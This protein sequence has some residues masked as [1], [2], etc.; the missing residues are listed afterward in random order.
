MLASSK[1]PWAIKRGRPVLQR[2]YNFASSQYAAAFEGVR[3]AVDVAKLRTD[4]VSYIEAFDPS[5]WHTQPV[6]TL[7]R[8]EALS[9]S[10][11]GGGTEGAEPAFV[12]TL[13]AFNRVNGKQV[14]ASPLVL[15][16]VIEHCRD[17]TNKAAADAEG[18]TANPQQQQQQR[19]ALKLAI[20]EVE[21]RMLSA[22]APALIGNQA[23]DFAKQ[24]GVTE[25][26]ESLEA[27]PVEQR[28]NDD[29]LRDEAK[30]MLTVCRVPALVGAVSNFSNFL[31]LCRKTLRNLE[32]GVPVVVLSR[33][34]TT[35][36]VF[37]WVQLLQAELASQGSIDPGML[38]FLSCDIAGQRKL[39][40]A[41]PGSPLYLTGSRDVAAKIKALLPATFASTGGPNTM[42]AT[43]F[44]PSVA[45]AT[46]LGTQIENSGQCTAM[47]HLV[48]PGVAEADVEALFGSSPSASSP[49]SSPSLS[50][51]PSSSLPPS[52]LR[53]EAAVEALKTGSFDGLFGSCW[54]DSFAPAEG[55][56]R[57]SSGLPVA[58]RVNHPGSGAGGGGGGGGLLSLPPKGLEEHWRRVYLDVT[59]TT[60]P[61]RQGASAEA[62]S[63]VEDEAFL[64]DLGDWLVHEQPITLAI[65]EKAKRAAAAADDEGSGKPLTRAFPVARG[66]FERTSQVV[67]SVGGVEGS[68]STALSSG[69]EDCGDEG[70][71]MPAALTCQARPQDGE[72][73]GE[74]P[75]RKQL[76]S[77]TKFPVVVPSP[78]PGYHSTYTKAYLSS[79]AQSSSSSSSGGSGGA[80]AAEGLIEAVAGGGAKAEDDSSV[81]SGFLVCLHDYLLDACAQSPRVGVGKR[82]TL[83]GLQRPP[84]ERGDTVLRLGS[85]FNGSLGVVAA[86]VLPFVATNAHPQ[87]VVS[88]HAAHA[89]VAA[90]LQTA[91]A[92]RPLYVKVEDDESFRACADQKEVWN[93]IELGNAFSTSAS[94]LNDASKLPLVGHFVSILFPLG[95]IKSTRENDDEFLNAF[96]DSP[97]WLSIDQGN[98]DAPVV[99]EEEWTA[100]GSWKKKW[101]E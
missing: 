29:L 41:L 38:T 80:A 95:H 43:H 64:D 78:T 86:F 42:V 1:F 60:T 85:E 49:A 9:N 89:E 70:S 22:H 50:S 24:D 73:F 63:S 90:S 84:L 62:L 76:D 77:F 3:P 101:S 40:A 58:F 81:R 15:D 44:S 88:V 83:W 68:S 25:I 28:M 31:D 33:S 51:V 98:G 94:I 19:T 53:L 57:H 61:T 36:H 45:E 16:A 72:I 47:R 13:D 20:R 79:L 46:R 100:A 87:L 26:E 4:T 96:K 5:A 69:D 65:N 52:S 99:K 6:C 75:P 17:L 18:V 97:K 74:F 54:G 7:L 32:C 11:A 8:G 37:R 35:Q 66:L 92:E 23:L 12:D 55:Y 93:V 91:S 59:T 67:Y 27:N 48:C 10:W 14:L 56:T 82:T 71:P 2:S 39:M 34:N 21:Q 30:G